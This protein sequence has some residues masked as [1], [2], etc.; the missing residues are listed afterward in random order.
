MSTPATILTSIGLILLLGLATDAL[1]RF[2]RLPRVTLLLVLGFIIGPGGFDVIPGMGQ[3]WFPVVTDMALV[4]VGFLLGGQLTMPSLREHGREVMWLS[5]ATLVGTSVF[6]SL[7]MLLAGVPMEIALLLAGIATA[8]APAATA[9]VVRETRADGPF[10]RVLLGIVAIDDAWGLILFSL[11][12]AAAGLVTGQGDVFSA[13]GSG[14]L[15]VGGALLLGLALGIPSA[16]LS[17]RIRPGEP[18]LLEA[19][20]AVLLCGGLALWLEVSYLLAALVFG[21]TVANLA[22]HH[23][24]PFHAI[25]GIE[26]PFLVL[27]FIL[28]GASFHLESLRGLGSIGVLYIGLR[29]LGRFAGTRVGGRLGRLPGAQRRWMGLALMPQAGVALGMALVA[30]E[31]Y[32][33]IG[34]TIL[35]VVIG[36]TVF[37]ELFGPVC[38]RV[39]LCKVGEAGR[40]PS[41]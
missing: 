10:T 1:G 40:T 36:T 17:G 33:E 29:I 19:L 38:T 28:A 3:V 9:D 14:A 21:A 2:S 15:D 13:L 18:T 22:R 24:R 12:L 6:M 35:P 23:E 26:Q 37:F 5:V 31:R 4:M 8:T 41:P 16:Y 20:G 27:F 34:H 30:A 25:E 11:M 39:A 7:G 32:P